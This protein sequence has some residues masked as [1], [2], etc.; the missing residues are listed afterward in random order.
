MS[1]SANIL[2]SMIIAISHWEKA[3]LV[4]TT[5]DI[6]VID[7]NDAPQQV[8]DDRPAGKKANFYLVRFFPAG[9]FEN[10]EKPKKWKWNSEGGASARKR[11][12]GDAKKKAL[13]KG[14]KGGKKKENKGTSPPPAKKAK[15]DKEEHDEGDVADDP[16]DIKVR[17]WRHKL[18]KVFLSNKGDPKKED[19]PEMD[20]PFRTV[21]AYQST[22]IHYLMGRLGH[23]NKTRSSKNVYDLSN[24][25]NTLAGGDIAYPN[26]SSKK[27]PKGMSFE[28]RNVSFSYPGS[29]SIRPALSSINLSIKPGQLIVMVGSNSSGK[30]V[31]LKLL[32][33]FYDPTTAP[34]SILDHSLFPILLGENVGLGYAEKVDDAEMVERSAQK[35]GA[36]HC[37]KKLKQGKETILSMDN[38]T[39]G[40]NLPDDPYRTLQAELDKL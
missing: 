5:T 14:K 34:E 10:E 15:R 32:S 16:E 1:G 9:D 24:I 20:K 12:T 8:L 31:I 27:K 4:I 17:Q 6:Q 37:P 23:S 18:Q 21:E 25:A 35:G 33:R 3:H 22:T 39:Y 36:S 7:P 11:K 13:P 38:E 40:S 19:M 2:V 30:S 28:F 26:P 29:Q